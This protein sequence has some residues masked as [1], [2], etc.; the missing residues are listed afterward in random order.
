M[1]ISYEVT[2]VPDAR[3]AVQRDVIGPDQASE[4]IPQLIAR[5]G[6]VVEPAGP[7]MCISSMT[8][9]GLRIAAGWPIDDTATSSGAVEIAATPATRAAVH[10]LEPVDEPRELYESA[11]DADPP[12]TRIVWPLAG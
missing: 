3:F 1:E 4:A 5:V 8:P 10:V 9:E 2:D 6:E 7:P 12:V 11:P